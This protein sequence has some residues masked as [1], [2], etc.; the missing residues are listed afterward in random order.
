MIQTEKDFFFHL[1]VSSKTTKHRLETAK[2]CGNHPPPPL[3]QRKRAL[4]RR[5]QEDAP[6]PSSPCSIWSKYVLR[7][8][9]VCVCVCVCLPYNLGLVLIHS[10]NSTHD[11]SPPQICQRAAEYL[12]P[13]KTRRTF[14]KHPHSPIDTHTYET[15]T[16]IHTHTHTLGPRAERCMSAVSVLAHMNKPQ[17]AGFYWCPAMKK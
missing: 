6:S 7:S 12:Q 14:S 2:Q 9:S 15:H 8:L 1:E 11:R 4:D 16:H 17:W 3:P 5:G 10:W 13:K